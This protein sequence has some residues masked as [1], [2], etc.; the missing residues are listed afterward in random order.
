M[1]A[2]YN[3][4]GQVNPFGSALYRG[5]END[6]YNVETTLSPEMQG[7]VNR[8]MSLAGTDSERY[9]RPRGMMDLMQAIQGR[10]GQRYGLGSQTGGLPPPRE[11]T[12]PAME[13]D[14]Q[15]QVTSG[16][17]MPM[18]GG[19]VGQGYAQAAPDPVGGVG[20][21]YMAKPRMADYSQVPQGAGPAAPGTR[22]I[23]RLPNAGDFGPGIQ[24]GPDMGALG[25][26]YGGFGGSPGGMRGNASMIAGPEPDPNR[27]TRNKPVTA[28]PNQPI[29]GVP[30]GP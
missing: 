4:V 13:Y 26:M 28:N 17:A 14:F 25:A 29:P 7:L 27:P 5:N 19:K 24:G 9:Q 21:G 15:P 22:G 6:G 16:G 3:R 2:R 1:Q 10:V 12:P 30:P 20:G 8:G 23:G 11:S 18:N